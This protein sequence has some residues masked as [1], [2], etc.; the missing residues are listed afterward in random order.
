VSQF[1]EECR[2]EW[3]RLRV[4]DPVADEMAA[5]LAA[6]LDE[7]EAE[8]ASPQEVLGSSASDPRSFAASWAA[9]RGVIP[10]RSTGLLPRRSVTLGV[11]AAF[12][13]IAAVGAALVIFASPDASAPTAAISLPPPPALANISLGRDG[14]VRAAVATLEAER[15][16]TRAVLES[17]MQ[18]AAESQ[19]QRAAVATLEGERAHTRAVLESQMQ[20]WVQPNGA[21][22]LTLRPAHGQG[23]E[24]HRV[25]S[26][27][28]I[29]GI[30]GVILSLP[31]LFW[32]P[33]RRF[34]P[35]NPQT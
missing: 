22:V 20:V 35:S 19:M 21:T 11:T 33:S 32:S 17:Q 16:H 10:P 27:L 13:I 8:G 3:K 25:G 18:R 1:V 29:A 28:L 26:I 4:Q 24:I 23:V 7:A 12:T 31:L 9:E 6:D 14:Q 30:A 5:E 34:S 15:A 2:R